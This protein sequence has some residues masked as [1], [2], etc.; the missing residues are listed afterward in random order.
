MQNVELTA[1]MRQSFLEN[2]VSVKRTHGFEIYLNPEDWMVASSIA[3]FGNWDLAGTLVFHDNIRHGDAVVDV[4][5]DIGWFTLLASALVGSKGKV[6]SFEPDP[7]SFDFLSRSVT[8][9]GFAQVMLFQECISDRDGFETLY[10]SKVPGQHSMIGDR[11]SK[12]DE[13]GTSVRVPSRK[14]DTMLQ[15]LNT[16]RIDLLK[17]DAEGAEP[18]IVSGASET[19]GQKRVR[20]IY[21]ECT[22]KSWGSY[23]RLIEELHRLFEVYLVVS[24][25][26]RLRFAR[27]TA[28]S[29]PTDEGNLYLRLRE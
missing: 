5:A 26:P 13:T 1:L 11:I 3:T 22:P 19:L 16:N 4:G 21:M 15:Q 14:L 7:S 27:L 12:A 18:R 23:G 10:L 20:N 9:N 17:I 25:F 2:P 24:S 8:H 6:L 29:M 28:Q